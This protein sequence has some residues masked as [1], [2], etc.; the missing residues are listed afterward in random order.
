MSCGHNSM[1]A[2]AVLLASVSM[3]QGFPGSG[4]Y[5][6]G[7]CDSLSLAKLKC[8]FAVCCPTEFY[9]S[10]QLFLDGVHE[11]S[12]RRDESMVI[13]EYSQECFGL[14]HISW[15]FDLGDLLRF[16]RYG[17]IP[18]WSITCPKNCILSLRN[19][20]FAN[21]SFILCS[22]NLWNTCL[23]CSKCSV[24]VKDNIMTSSI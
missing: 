24:S 19:S 7:S 14:V 8:A 6:M 11:V 23:M 1:P 22:L 3:I 12:E 4:W 10:F 16:F 20:H 2:I 17:Y 18:L 5:S 13:V 15:R 9:I 21:F